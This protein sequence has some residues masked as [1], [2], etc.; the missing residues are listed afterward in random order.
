MLKQL[1]VHG[2]MQDLKVLIQFLTHLVSQNYLIG[3]QKPYFL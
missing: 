3:H 1:Q 2:I